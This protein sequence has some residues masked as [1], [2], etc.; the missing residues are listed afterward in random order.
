MHVLATGER[1]QSTKKA[2]P[3]WKLGT[4]LNT[5][6]SERRGKG[7]DLAAAQTGLELTRARYKIPSYE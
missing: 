4:S 6:G 5:K 7:V 1:D 3:P 2:R